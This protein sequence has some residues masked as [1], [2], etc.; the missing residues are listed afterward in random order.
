MSEVLENTDKTVLLENRFTEIKAFH[1][2]TL[3]FDNHLSEEKSVQ[4][5]R[6]QHLKA[7][8]SGFFNR[9]TSITEDCSV[10]LSGHIQLLLELSCEFYCSFPLHILGEKYLYYNTR[11]TTWA[12]YQFQKPSGLQ[13]SA[14]VGGWMAQPCGE[15]HN[16]THVNEFHPT[17]IKKCRD[18]RRCKG[19][20]RSSAGHI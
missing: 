6:T 10:H 18:G 2:N 20:Q 13:H 19:R 1:D 16:P 12:S 11:R 5:P 3:F 7:S 4:M 17:Q 14:S 15:N 8:V 9:T